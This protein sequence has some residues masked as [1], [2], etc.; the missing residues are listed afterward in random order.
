MDQWFGGFFSQGVAEAVVVVLAVWQ[1]LVL[2]SDVSSSVCKTNSNCNWTFIAL[3]LPNRKGNL[4]S[5]K[6]K[7]VNQSQSLGTEKVQHHG[8]HQGE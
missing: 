1:V 5:N 6:T 3:N 2:G 7:T 8:E 4:R